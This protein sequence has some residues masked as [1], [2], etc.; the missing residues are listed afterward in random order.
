MA[1]IRLADTAVL[2]T[3]DVS[4]VA[5]PYRVGLYRIHVRRA[6]SGAGS[7]ALRVRG[8]GAPDFVAGFISAQTAAGAARVRRAHPG[9]HRLRAGPDAGARR[10]PAPLGPV[11]FRDLRG[12][13]QTGGLSWLWQRIDSGAP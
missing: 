4:H 10:R 11:T 7:A 3:R 12:G 2:R 6:P 13:D 9:R 8:K 1:D 5:A